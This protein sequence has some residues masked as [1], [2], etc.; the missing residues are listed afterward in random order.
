MLRA[1]LVGISATALVAGA[2]AALAGWRVPGL[3]LGFLGAAVLLGTLFERWRY[4]TGTTL[5]AERWERTSE[6]FEDPASG[7]ILDVY[8]NPRSGE[9]RYI[10]AGAAKN[11]SH[12]H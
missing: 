3:Y 2:I 6:R 8:F 11:P 1:A 9:R 7:E 10:A 12:P 4:R 5:D